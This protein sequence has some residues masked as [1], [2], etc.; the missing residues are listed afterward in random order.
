MIVNIVLPLLLT[1]VLPVNAAAVDDS[2]ESLAPRTDVNDD[3]HTLT[4]FA[5]TGRCYSYTD[6]ARTNAEKANRPCR[7][8][9]KTHG[10]DGKTGGVYTL[11]LAPS[12]SLPLS[13]AF[14]LWEAD[15]ARR[16]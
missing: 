14:E 2:S 13:I 12:L 8:C 5:K 11:K 16:L 15:A 4:E 3:K 9:C 7:A 6:P 10:G 1:T